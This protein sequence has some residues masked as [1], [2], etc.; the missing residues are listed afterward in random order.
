MGRFLGVFWVGLLG[1]VGLWGCS[2]SSGEPECSSQQPDCPA[3]RVYLFDSDELSTDL[4][5]ASLVLEPP[6]QTG[7][8]LADFFVGMESHVEGDIYTGTQTGG[9]IFFH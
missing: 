2:F 4:S 5:Q 7:D 8:G 6:D 3:G 9:V 1:L